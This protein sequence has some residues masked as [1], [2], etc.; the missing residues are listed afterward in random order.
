MES[1]FAIFI[2]IASI[3]TMAVYVSSI[4][5]VI[6]KSTVTEV[7]TC[8]QLVSSPNS[9]SCHLTRSGVESDYNCSYNTSTKK[10]TCTQAK[11]SSGTS[12]PMTGSETIRKFTDSQIPLGLKGALDSAIKSQ[13]SGLV[14]GQSST[15]S[16]NPPECPKTGPIPPNCTMKPPLK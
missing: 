3:L 9:A 15:I 13:N 11:T 10:W 4:N 2:V 12:N 5:S 1:K 14:T 6:A 16:P 7:W 8:I